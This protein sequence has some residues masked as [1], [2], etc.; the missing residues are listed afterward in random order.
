MIAGLRSLR[1]TAPR[2]AAR[3]F[4]FAIAF[5]L[6][7]MSRLIAPVVRI[8]FGVLW[9]GR[10]GP[11][12][13]RPEVHLCEAEAGLH[14]RRVVDLF[15]AEGAVIP[16]PAA[17]GTTREEPPCNAQLLKMWRRVLPIHPLVRYLA[18][19]S[20]RIP[21]SAAH[22]AHM[23]GERDLHGVL[24]GRAPHL[25]FTT[26]E[27]ARA[28]AALG[29]L[30]LPADARFV[31]FHGRDRAYLSTAY[32]GAGA[33]EYHDYRDSDIAT[34]LP[35]VRALVDSGLYAVRMGSVV[36]APLVAEDPRIIDYAATG[37]R[38]E[39][40]DLVLAARCEFFIGNDSGLLFVPVA[41]RRRV[42]LANFTLLATPPISSRD[43]LFITKKVWSTRDHRF[44]AFREMTGLP[45]E[46]EGFVSRG[47]EIVDNSAQEILDLA[48][49]MEQ[50]SS[51]TWRS[52]PEDEELQDRLRRIL[53]EEGASL[54]PG[55]SRVGAQFLREN[56]ALLD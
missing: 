44:L 37:H 48:M 56:R 45:Y 19:A 16:E 24:A 35:A 27:M 39:L 54:G 28:D 30:G 23:T 33:W 46:S 42:G 55:L 43:D 36:G 22:V 32:P 3:T 9:T 5:F 7:I 17:S 12:A 51:G 52:T 14:G 8:R 4:L 6:V 21:L 15:Y 18:S 2:L 40:L 31:A 34:Y 38:S 11:L 25:R 29:A 47:L 13:G 53:R 10:I 20:R 41:F 26:D 1:R 49:E 50:R